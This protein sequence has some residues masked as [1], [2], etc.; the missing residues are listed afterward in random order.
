MRSSL[1]LVGSI[2]GTVAWAA[3]NDSGWKKTDEADGVTVFSK[4]TPGSAIKSVKGTG[5]VEAPVE[6]V[7]LVLVDDDRAPEWVDSLTEAKVVKVVSPAEYV[8]YNH[9]A[10]P[11]IVSNRDF[12]THVR[13]QRDAKTKT[14]VMVSEPA[15]DALRPSRKGVVRGSLAARY[16]LEPAN[17]GKA[18]RLT[19]EIHADPKGWLP[20]WVINFFQKDWA[21]ETIQGIRKQAAKKDLKP[22]A[23]F[24][25][26]LA[27]INAPEAAVDSDAAQ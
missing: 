5:L 11:F 23:P 12:V 3:P 1:W 15:D 18:T 17:D 8:E 10:M 2:L 16:V 13:M 21:H 22:P 19:V 20:S 9:V 14:V 4:A 27:S 6:T 25:P 24:S 7:A 26:F